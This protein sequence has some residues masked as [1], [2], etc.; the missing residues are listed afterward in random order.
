VRLKPHLR[1]KPPKGRIRRKVKSL[2]NVVLIKSNPK[3][4]KYQIL[5]QAETLQVRLEKASTANLRPKNSS[6]SSLSSITAKTLVN[7][8]RKK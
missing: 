2:N 8:S 1:K 6:S 3:A 5:E 4:H 7:T